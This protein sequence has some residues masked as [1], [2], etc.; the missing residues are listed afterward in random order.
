[1]KR[2][3]RVLV[4]ILLSAWGLALLSGCLFI[5]TFNKTTE[6]TNVSGE[7]GKPGSKAPLIVGRARRED[8]VRVLGTPHY[9][10]PNGSRA[11]YNW[12]VLNGIWVWPLCF[13]AYDQDGARALVLEFDRSGV[14][15]S[16][17][18]AK[19]NNDWLNAGEPVSVPLPEGV[20]TWSPSDSW[21]P[22]APTVDSAQP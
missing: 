14:L 21:P 20:Q 7:V 2:R 9:A 19:R 18:V 10:S 5:P 6:G 22:V 16:F 15:H 11:V 13:Q 4:P 17:Y 1:M 3:L 12:K 8:V